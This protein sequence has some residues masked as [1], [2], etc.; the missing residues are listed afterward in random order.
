[1]LQIPYDILNR[2][3]RKKLKSENED[4]VGSVDV[5]DYTIEESTDNCLDYFCIATK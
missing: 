2:L 5:D 4:V 3:N 1:M